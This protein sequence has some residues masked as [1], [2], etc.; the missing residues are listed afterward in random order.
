MDAPSRFYR[1][2]LCG[3]LVYLI[4][5]GKGTMKCCGQPMTNL[6]ANSTDG[7]IEKHVPVV[8]GENP[9][10]IKVGE[11]PHPMEPEHHIEWIFVA[12]A[13]TGAVFELDVAG[14]P[15]TTFFASTDEP[16]TVYAYC[17][18]HGLF[19]AAF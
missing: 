17:N 9:Y 12:S 18:I 6:V 13:S 1:C 3:N 8:A 7:A 14:K 16:V 4:D 19:S 2:E 11:L 15:E 10:T 5:E